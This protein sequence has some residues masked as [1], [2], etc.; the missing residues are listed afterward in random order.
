MVANNRK[1][2]SIG[3]TAAVLVIPLA[4]G[5]C[6]G[7]G[8]EKPETASQPAQSG[9]M[10]AAPASGSMTNDQMLQSMQMQINNLQMQ[11]N[12]M[13]QQLLQLQSKQ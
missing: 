8:E 11:V 9:E 6:G 4:L 3:L 5:A 7:G 1:K 2:I 10:T 13:Q 12:Q